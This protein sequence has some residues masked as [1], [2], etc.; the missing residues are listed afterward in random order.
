M[1]IL[2]NNTLLLGHNLQLYKHNMN[3]F[4]F[5][6][7]CSFM[8]QIVKQENSHVFVHSPL[9]LQLNIEKCTCI[10]CILNL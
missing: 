1:Y 4:F 3:S 7:L 2:K 8:R 6:L 9:T 10:V 5:S